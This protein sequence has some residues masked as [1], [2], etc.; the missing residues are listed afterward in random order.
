MLPPM[1]PEILSTG[2]QQGGE[3]LAYIYCGTKLSDHLQVDCPQSEVFTLYDDPSL[4]YFVIHS[5]P[6]TGGV[7][8]ERAM[9]AVIFPG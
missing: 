4:R 1:C 3:H 5:Q 7:K 2:C 6:S 8:S 9:M